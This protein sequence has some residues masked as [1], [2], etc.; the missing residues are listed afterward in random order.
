[1]SEFGVYGDLHVSLDD[2]FVATAE[3]RRPPNNFFDLDLI[4]GLVQAFGDLDKEDG[5]RAIVLCSEGKNFCAGAQFGQDGE[6]GGS[7]IATNADGTPRHLY[8]AAFDLFSL[9]KPVVAAIQGAAVGGGFGVA[10]FADFR[11]A[12]PEARFTANFSRLGFHQGFGLTVTLPGL[13]GQ[14]KALEMLYTGQRIGGEDA[15]TIG[16]ADALAPLDELRDAAHAFALEIARSAPLA[17]ESI[18]Q[19]MRGHM[20]QAIKEA[21]DREKSEQDRLRETADWKEGVNAMNERRLPN[22]QRK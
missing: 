17:V 14:Q 11:V 10:C 2:D 18:R 16:L 3:I 19:T 6:R 21:T 22:F 5:C 9:N 12:A 20:P 15:L 7:I 1:M 4:D 13:V 8:D